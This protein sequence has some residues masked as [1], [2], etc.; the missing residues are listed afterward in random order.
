MRCPISSSAHNL[1]GSFALYRFF[2]AFLLCGRTRRFRI[3]QLSGLRFRRGKN[4]LFHTQFSA[5]ASPP[6]L[7]PIK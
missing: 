5:A 4:R 2:F 3:A 1:T 6:E 7:I